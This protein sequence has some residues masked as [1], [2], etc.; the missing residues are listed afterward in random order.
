M[1]NA[2][3]CLLFNGLSPLHKIVIP[4]LIGLESPIFIGAAEGDEVSEVVVAWTDDDGVVVF[5][6]RHLS[7]NV[8]FWDID[9]QSDSLALVSHRVFRRHGPVGSPTSTKPLP[10][11]IFCGVL[12]IYYACD[13]LMVGS[14]ALETH[15]NGTMA[16]VCSKCV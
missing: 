8:F 1:R 14:I 5:V 3:G 13:K 2:V 6:G 4:L 15:V 12:Y 10:V 16:L 7:Y 9:S 11:A